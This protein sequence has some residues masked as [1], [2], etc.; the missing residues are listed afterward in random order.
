MVLMPVVLLLL[1]HRQS[2]HVRRLLQ[3][4]LPCLLLLLQWQL[5]LLFVM[6]AF[7]STGRCEGADAR[8]QHGN[9]QQLPQQHGQQ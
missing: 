5:Q 4:L 2:Q 7:I 1:S 6:V 8:V 9:R 3:L